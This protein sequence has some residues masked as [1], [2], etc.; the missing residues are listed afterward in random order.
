MNIQQLIAL[1]TNVVIKRDINNTWWELTFDMPQEAYEM[2]VAEMRWTVLEGD[3]NTTLYFGMAESGFCNGWVHHSDPTTQWGC[4]GQR[5]PLIMADDTVKEIKGPW[6][7]RPAVYMYHGSVPY[8]EVKIKTNHWGTMAQ[9]LTQ[10]AIDA[11]IVHFNLPFR[12]VVR[13]DDLMWY[14]TEEDNTRET[15]LMI[16]TLKE[17]GE[18]SECDFCDRQVPS[19][20]IGEND[21]HYMSICRTCDDKRHGNPTNNPVDPNEPF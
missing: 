13:R 10:E 16:E 12:T 4:G 9:G 11:I 7:G 8:D 2:A 20:G 5:I 3:A 17:Y 15:K 19:R 6:T 18:Y 21:Q 14:E 1:I